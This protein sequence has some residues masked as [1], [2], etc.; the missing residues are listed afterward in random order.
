[1]IWP[2]TGKQNPNKQLH[3]G[4]FA[5]FPF[6]NKIPF[7]KME[8]S[9]KDFYKLFTP[10]NSVSTPLSDLMPD[11]SPFPKQFY[12]LI[13]HFYPMASNA[14]WVWK[15]LCSS[16]QHTDFSGGSDATRSLAKQLTLDLDSRI[17]TMKFVQGGGMD[18][19]INQFFDSV[20]TYGKFAGEIELDPN[21]DK[22]NSVKILDPFSVRFANNSQRT[23]YIRDPRSHVFYKVNENTFFYYALDMS[24]DNPAGSAMLDSCWSLMKTAEDML[25]DMKLSSA[26]AGTPRLHI[27]IK[28]PPIVEGETIENYSTRCA[29]YFD[30]YMSQFQEISADD[31]FY[32][33]DDLTIGSVGGANNQ[34]FVWKINRQVIDEE[35]ISGFHLYPWV[36]AKSFSTTKN[37]VRSQFDLIMAQVVS[38]QSSAKRFSEWIRNTNLKLAGITDCTVHHSFSTVRDPARKDI[39]IADS[40]EIANVERKTRDG[41]ISPDDAAR[42]LGYQK[43]FNP[44]IFPFPL[45]KQ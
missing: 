12:R 11:G 28:Q 23:P 45:P 29:S 39:A 32:S 38:V 37:W 34:G 20:F 27:K 9:K 17:S 42:E 4:S 24:H 25:E 3:K 30:S 21:L 22:I 10:A 43:S 1:M 41:F 2:F 44:D 31:N 40:F 18:F 26:N 19:L 36:L 13:S 16:H 33:W 6:K 8:V 7:Q 14:I 35:I 15:N 5:S